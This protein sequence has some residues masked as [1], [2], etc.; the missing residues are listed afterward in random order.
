MCIDSLPS[1]WWGIG[2]MDGGCIGL[3]VCSYM[4]S[5]EF[6]SLESFCHLTRVDGWFDSSEGFWDKG[7]LSLKI[8]QNSILNLKRGSL[9][10]YHIN[11]AIVL[12]WGKGRCCRDASLFLFQNFPFSPLFCSIFPF[13]SQIMKKVSQV[14][15][16]Y[17]KSPYLCT[18]FP[19]GSMKIDLW[20]TANKKY[21]TALRPCF[22][23]RVTSISH[24][25]ILR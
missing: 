3:I 22:M 5:S 18:R 9:L 23:A 19:K 13:F 1:V 12:R 10:I 6:S 4:S 2:L 20:Q 14:L 15:G 25:F 7:L 8:F 17:L 16:Q 21:K 11:C 24:S